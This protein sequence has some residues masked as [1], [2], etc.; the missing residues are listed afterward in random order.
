MENIRK[1]ENWKDL[2]LRWIGHQKYNKDKI[3]EDDIMEVIIQKLEMIL[4]TNQSEILGYDGYSLGVNLEY[5]L[6]ETKISNDV[7]QGKIVQQINEFIPELNIIG[8]DIRLEITEG[9]VRDILEIYIDINGYDLE[10]IFE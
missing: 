9:S 10:F 2:P 8:Y 6:W 1:T 5:Y 3:I 4:F 7:I